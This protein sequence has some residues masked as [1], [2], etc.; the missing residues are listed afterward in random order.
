[1]KSSMRMRNFVCIALALMLAFSA[2]LPVY[3]SDNIQNDDE[4]ITFD[5]FYNS[6]KAE[7]AKYNVEFE[8]E[9][10]NLDYIYT[11]GFL[12]EQL[13]FARD[14]CEGLT[15]IVSDE[16]N[17]ADGSSYVIPYSM[18]MN[19]IWNKDL[20]IKSNHSLAPGYVDVALTC[21]GDVD[22]QNSHTIS[23]RA[24][25]TEKTAMNLGENN[26]YAT[27]SI[28]SKGDSVYVTLR[29]SVKF[30]WTEPNTYTV[31]STVVS[32][33]FF[34]DSFNPNSYTV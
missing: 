32:E 20:T 17:L 8:I 16:S 2:I 12:N 27:C 29:G 19:Y 31:F 7:Y 24:S 13:A 4:V 15:I 21:S 11:R 10:P 33:P 3:A 25:V 18:V 34:G 5:Y 23:A 1:M 6:L 30:S 22:I 28:S 9:K 26:L 14:Y